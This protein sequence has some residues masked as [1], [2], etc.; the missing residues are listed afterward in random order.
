[1]N[2]GEAQNNKERKVQCDKVKVLNGNKVKV[3]VDE[4]MEREIRR[5]TPK[6]ISSIKFISVSQDITDTFRELAKKKR[7]ATQ[8]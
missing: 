6:D 2:K 8:Q 4:L 5:E 7:I 1:M 3:N